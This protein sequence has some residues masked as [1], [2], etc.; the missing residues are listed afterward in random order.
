METEMTVQMFWGIGIY[1]AQQ[2]VFGLLVLVCFVY[3]AGV[4]VEPHACSTTKLLP[5][6]QSVSHKLPRLASNSPSSCFALLKSWDH[7]PV[8]P[9]LKC[10]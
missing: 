7:R 4:Y 9:K 8:T 10:L 1:F 2:V 6:P 3:G 5:Y